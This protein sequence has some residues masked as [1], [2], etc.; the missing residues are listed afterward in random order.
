VACRGH[1]GFDRPVLGDDAC[2]RLADRRRVGYV[3]DIRCGWVDIESGDGVA[4]L[5]ERRGDGGADA[6]GDPVTIAVRV[7]KR[8]RPI[9]ARSVSRCGGAP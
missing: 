7:T 8:R 1:N 6:G 9:D 3:D 5:L 4:V 2:H